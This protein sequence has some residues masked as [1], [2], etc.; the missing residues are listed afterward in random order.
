MER[1]RLMFVLPFKKHRF[2]NV[3]RTF[4]HTCIHPSRY[5]HLGVFCVVNCMKVAATLIPG[6]PVCSMPALAHAR[7]EQLKCWQKGGVADRGMHRETKLLR[8]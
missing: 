6:V 8:E 2:G 1:I 5:F 3:V 4:K 7:V